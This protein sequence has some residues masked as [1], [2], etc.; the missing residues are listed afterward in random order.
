MSNQGVLR[1]RVDGVTKTTSYSSD[2]T[3]HCLS[4]AAC[5]VAELYT[6]SAVTYLSEIVKAYGRGNTL[7]GALST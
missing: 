6:R 1:G 3:P 2:T 7:R 5:K 4:D